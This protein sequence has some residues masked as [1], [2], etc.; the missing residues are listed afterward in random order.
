MQSRRMRQA[1]GSVQGSVLPAAGVLLYLSFLSAA[2]YTIWGILLK[3]NPVSRVAVYGFSNPVIGVF[4]SAM[5]LGEDGQAFTLKN[6]G[7][8][9]L[10]CA[11]ILVVNVTARSGAVGMKNG[12]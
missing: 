2:A 3:Y 8:L 10:V 1:A 12:G 6:V 5:L 4:L 7:A 9:A 11:G